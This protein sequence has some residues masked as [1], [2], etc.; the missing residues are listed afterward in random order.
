M[1]G[2]FRTVDVG[3]AV[4]ELGYDVDPAQIEISV[5]APGYSLVSRFKRDSLRRTQG[6]V[7]VDFVMA[8]EE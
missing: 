5:T 2:R 6:F 4:T 7:E 1:I 8:L 3:R